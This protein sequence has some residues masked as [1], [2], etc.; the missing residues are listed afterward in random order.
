MLRLAFPWALALIPLLLALWWTGLR[1]K[2][3]RQ[4][5]LAYSDLGLVR[6]SK[7]VR[8]TWE[9]WL[10]WGLVALGMLSLCL[11]LARP[12]A[13]KSREV[14]KSSGVNIMLCLD[15]STSMKAMDLMPNRLE[16]AKDLSERFVQERPGDRIGVVLFAGTAFTQCPLTLD[17]QALSQLLSSAN[18]GVT[19]TDGTAIGTALATSVNRLKN[20]PGKS[21]VIVLLTDGRSNA[22]EIDPLTGAKLAQQFGIKI[23]TI[24]VGATGN[25]MMALDP[26]LGLRS[27]GSDLDVESLTRIAQ[28]TGGRFYH[29]AD[30]RA[31]ADVYDEINRLEKVEQTSTTVTDYSELFFYPLALGLAFIGLGSLLERTI[32]E[33]LP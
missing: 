2:T 33:E 1:S 5:A 11:A 28:A 9:S 6:W 4:A 22:G 30:N 10:P 7:A 27:V 3:Q 19:G 26:S 24:G 23:Y 12:Q 31:L 8:P 21:K 17:H 15:T 25:T 14:V 29:A 20:L 16:A 32:L 13:G 18:F